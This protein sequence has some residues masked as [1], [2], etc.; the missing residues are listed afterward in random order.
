[1]PRPVV[2]AYGVRGSIPAAGRQYARFGGDTASF[3]VVTPAGSRIF[4]DAGTGILRAADEHMHRRRPPPAG[5]KFALLLSHSH[6]DHVYGLG[7][8][9]LR[10]HCLDPK[11]SAPRVDI[12][13]PPGIDRGLD[14]FYDGRRTW[15]LVIGSG[16]NAVGTMPCVDRAWI[17]AVAGGEEIAIDSS[18]RARAMLGSH[19]VDGGVAL[20]RLEFGGRKPSSIV[21]ATDNEF[22]FLPGGVP[23]PRA[24]A[25]KLEYS[26]FIEGAD[27]LIADAQYTR[28]EY[29]KTGENDRKGFGHAYLEQIVELA[30]AAG[31]RRLLVTH[32]GRHT[33]SLLLA[34]ERAARRLA[35]KMKTDMKVEFA[36]QG[37]SYPVG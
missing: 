27:L 13:G 14:Q 16:D 33:D 7:M 26:G 36:R 2:H 37:K 5:T 19:P 32:H 21:Y 23:N 24:G 18:T 31:V 20:Y 6:A 1:M 34:R 22:D 29:F 3:V 17:R 8:C 4:L 25:L 35:L 12:F 10:W 9:A 15:P 11:S 30:S 28:D